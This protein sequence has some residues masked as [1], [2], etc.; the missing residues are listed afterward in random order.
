MS[1]IKAFQTNIAPVVC[2]CGLFIIYKYTAVK[3]N[4]L[5][6][7]SHSLQIQVNHT[8][9]ALCLENIEDVRF[10]TQ[11]SDITLAQRHNERQKEDIYKN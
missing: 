7:I 6:Y 8:S 4:N 11:Y 10:Q 3:K 1:Q 2:E 9:T 5:L